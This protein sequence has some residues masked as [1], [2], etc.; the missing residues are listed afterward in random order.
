MTFLDI[1]RAKRTSGATAYLQFLLDNSKH[2]NH[3][4]AFFEGHDDPSFYYR[5]IVDYVKNPQIVHIYKCG[6]KKEVYATHS[7]I[8]RHD[9]VKNFTLFFVD[10]DLSDILGE[11][12]PV[13]T[14]I[15]VTEYYSIES[16]IVTPEVVLSIIA[17]TFHFH[18]QSDGI[19]YDIFRQKFEQELIRFHSLITPLMAWIIDVRTKGYHPN[20]DNID[21]S[22]IFTFNDNLEVELINDIDYASIEATCKLPPNCTSIVEVNEISQKLLS[23]NPKTYVR[24]KYELWFIVKFLDKLISILGKF[25]KLKVKL[26]ISEGTAIAYLSSKAHHPP[27][28]TLFLS[29]NLSLHFT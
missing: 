25:E 24:G 5:S 2:E 26:R 19:D 17:E 6:N 9:D 27:S 20:L 13:D 1:L 15:Y 22:R 23:S 12:F 16:Y 14:N 10:K 21:L 8:R 29:T 7:K 4:F 11:Q 18:Y 3:V 28:L